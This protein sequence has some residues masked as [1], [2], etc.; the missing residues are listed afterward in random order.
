MDERI[1]AAAR[2]LTL[3]PIGADVAEVGGIACRR[4][5]GIAEPWACQARCTTLPDRAE[6]D[7]AVGWLGE[8]S[9]QWTVVVAGELADAEVF[10]A[11]EPWLT[12]PVMVRTRVLAPAGVAG[13]T[14]RPAATP[15]EFLSVYGAELAPLVTPQ[16]LGDPAHRYLVAELDH[17]V[18]ACAIT[19]RLAD[20]AYINGVT[21]VPDLRGQGIGTAIS[22]AAAAAG[23][24]IGADLIWLEAL[25][26]AQPVYRRLGF[27]V[28]GE[29]VLLT[30]R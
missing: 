25:A 29:H 22:A 9:P 1:T 6:L 24:E 21:V 2:A 20:T 28:I 18:V 3:S 26:K 19:R 12:L 14:I 15:G 5:R 17:R 13:L 23:D 11:F 10:A 8:R 7:R 16:H 30:A 4:F 27:D